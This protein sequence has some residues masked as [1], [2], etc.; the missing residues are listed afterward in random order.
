[1]YGLPRPH[2][3]GGGREQ[4]LHLRRRLPLGL[5]PGG[6]EVEPLDL[7]GGECRPGLVEVA[8]LDRVVEGG[9][10]VRGPLLEQEAHDGRAL[11]EDRALERRGV[12]ERIARVDAGAL[13]HE[14]PDDL[15]RARA[16]GRGEGKRAL[17]VR[18]VR[19]DP[20]VEELCARPRSCR[21]APPPRARPR[22]DRRERPA[23]GRA[24]RR[25]TSS[26]EGLLPDG[27]R[28]DSSAGEHS[29]REAVAIAGEDE[30]C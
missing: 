12:E 22:G 17:R 19:R 26:I 7:A 14:E 27:R 4:R 11:V 20:V 1:M 29:S 10:R 13:L 28:L 16:R 6:E 15:E 2:G 21:A 25:A 9:V 23:T 8:A 30:L 18:R 24:W 5:L 3:G